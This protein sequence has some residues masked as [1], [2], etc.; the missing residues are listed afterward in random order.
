MQPLF[1]FVSSRKKEG[2]KMK[3]SPRGEEEKKVE[4]R[5][6]KSDSEKKERVEERG[7]EKKTFLGEGEGKALKFG[8]N[9]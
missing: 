7:G 5:R 1:L 4:L 8:F 9:T 2:E 3:A 6:W